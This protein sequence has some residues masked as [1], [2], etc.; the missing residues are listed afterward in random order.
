[1][2][3]HEVKNST[4]TYVKRAMLDAYDIINKYENVYI[5]KKA[6]S[7]LTIRFTMRNLNIAI[8]IPTNYPFIAPHIVINKLP[9]HFLLQFRCCN[10]LNN[11]LQK[12]VILKHKPGKGDINLCSLSLVCSDNWRPGNQ[13]IHIC[14]EM[15]EIIILRKRCLEKYCAKIIFTKYH[16]KIYNRGLAMNIEKYL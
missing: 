15:E 7:S 16:S 4:P 14:N 9:Y 13:L 5:S 12:E 8:Y 1:M 2:L 6:D 3:R 11:I 10:D